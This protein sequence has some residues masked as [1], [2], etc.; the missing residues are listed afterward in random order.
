MVFHAQL[1]EEE[2]NG[3]KVKKVPYMQNSMV[4]DTF[5]DFQAYIFPLLAKPRD[6][7]FPR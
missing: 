7:K 4:A 2:T 5:L 6:G 3:K 1:A